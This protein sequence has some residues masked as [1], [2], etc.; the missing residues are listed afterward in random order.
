ML[1]MKV[2]GMRIFR[3][4]SEISPFFEGE[5]NGGGEEGKAGKTQ[6]QLSVER[7]FRNLRPVFCSHVLVSEAWGPAGTTATCGPGDL[8]RGL[9]ACWPGNTDRGL[10]ARQH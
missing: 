5:R 4:R 6:L 1:F 2:V 8:F 7:G 9:T 3:R 10:S